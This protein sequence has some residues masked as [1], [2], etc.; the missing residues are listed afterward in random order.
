M[1]R[2]FLDANVL[3][4]MAYGSKALS[5]LEDKARQG[6]FKIIASAYVVEEASRNLSR[7]DHLSRLKEL[8]ADLTI[9][10]EADPGMPC[11]VNLPAKDVPVLMA[12]IQSRA[13]HLI[14]GDLSHFGQYRGK[15][16]A[17]VLIC[18]PRDYVVADT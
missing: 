8:L 1:D 11:P 12:A 14:T 13:T 2:L 4:S 18:T 17:G 3:F 6:R 5:I 16:I 9:V 10:P 15:N 7:L